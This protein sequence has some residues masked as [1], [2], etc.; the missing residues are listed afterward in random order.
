MAARGEDVEFIRKPFTPSELA[1]KVRGV[2]QPDQLRV[3]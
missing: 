2:L 3:G 1:E